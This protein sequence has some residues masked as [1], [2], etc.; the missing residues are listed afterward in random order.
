[1]CCTCQGGAV[2]N[3][4][5]CCMHMAQQLSGGLLCCCWVCCGFMA[6][7][8]LC[9]HLYERSRH[10][11]CGSTRHWDSLAQ[12]L[13]SPQ[14]LFW[15]D[16]LVWDQDQDHVPGNAAAQ[17]GFLMLD[18][19]LKQVQGCTGWTRAGSAC[20]LFSADAAELSFFGG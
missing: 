12:T 18:S 2:T 5:F 13:T 16:D 6:S 17:R 19:P 3:K 10:S 7:F 4:H 9:R 20:L 8:W 15:K 1:M 14:A 11:H